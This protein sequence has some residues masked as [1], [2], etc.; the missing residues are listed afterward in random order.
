MH[1]WWW[2]DLVGWE[3][4]VLRIWIGVKGFDRRGG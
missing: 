4:G 1:F 2:M 3:D